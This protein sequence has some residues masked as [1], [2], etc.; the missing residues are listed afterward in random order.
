MKNKSNVVPEERLGKGEILKVILMVVG[1]S[2]ILVAGAVCPGLLQLV[3]IGRR[4]YFKMKTGALRQAVHRLDKKGWLVL[5]E[6]REGCRIELTAR[7]KAELHAYE[8]GEK[9]LKKPKHWDQ[10]W[11]LLIFDI[12]E[13]RKAVRERVRKFLRSLGFF[14]LQDSVWV[15]PYECQEILALLRTKYGIRHEALYLRVEFLDQDHW[16]RKEF[17]LKTR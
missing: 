17:G 7:G 2:G 15:F 8:I 13:K 11:R 3:K 16:L 6:K 1:V 9:C 10:K 4:E 5:R 14:R 12:P